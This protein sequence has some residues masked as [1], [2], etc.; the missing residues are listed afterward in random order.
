[1]ADH[2]IVDPL[3]YRAILHATAAGACSVA[4][5][6]TGQD[7]WAALG[8]EQRAKASVLLHQAAT[9]KACALARSS[10]V[11]AISAREA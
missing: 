7:C 4:A 2:E 6:E 5:R 8:G 3:L 10:S 9:L 11:T 1:M